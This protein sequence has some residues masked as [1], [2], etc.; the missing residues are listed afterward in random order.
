[1][2]NKITTT[3]ELLDQIKEACKGLDEVTIDNILDELG[4]RS[5]APLLLFAGIITLA[6]VVGDIPGVPTMMGILVLLTTVQIFLQQE[7]F[8]FPK[9]ILERSLETSKVEKGVDWTGC[10]NRH[11]T[12]TAG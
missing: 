8:W 3:E 7:H 10:I 1:M 12:L 4:R 6:P 11:H 2:G 5:F 9:W